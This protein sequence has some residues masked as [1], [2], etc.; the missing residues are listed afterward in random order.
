MYQ[1]KRLENPEVSSSIYGLMSAY[2]VGFKEYG[3]TLPHGNQ[4]V[5]LRDYPLKG[6]RK[7]DDYTFEIT[8]K[9]EYAQF[10]FWLAM[11]FFSP[12]H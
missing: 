3:H 8:L 4:Y 1:I 7:I 5:D 2:I 12:I 11:E 9:G 10:L 6:L